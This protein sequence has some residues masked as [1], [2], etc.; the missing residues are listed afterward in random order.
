MTWLYDDIM[1]KRYDDTDLQTDRQTNLLKLDNHDEHIFGN[2][3]RD[4]KVKEYCVL[5]FP[6]FFIQEQSIV[7]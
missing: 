5:K 2:V 4:I 7:N 3:C 6:I 1:S